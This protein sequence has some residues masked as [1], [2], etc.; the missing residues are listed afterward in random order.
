ML[1]PSS[2]RQYL[3]SKGYIFEEI[4]E[5]GHKGLIIRGLQLPP[6]LFNV[7]QAD[8]LILLPSGYPDAAPD[9]FYLL[10][11]VTLAQ[12]QKYPKAAD[13]PFMFN[14][15]RWQRWSRHSNEWRP[16]IDGIW[17]MLKRVGQALEVAA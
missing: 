10:P 13:Q 4:A 14:K 9:M 3:Q 11:W 6:G 8:V 15:Q 16:G 5:N 17:T 2:D 12:T 1:L 7:S